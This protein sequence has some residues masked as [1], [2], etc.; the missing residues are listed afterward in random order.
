MRLF[1]PLE[2]TDTRLPPKKRI[3]G[4]EREGIS[5]AVQ[6]DEV[7]NAGLIN[8]EIGITPIVA[9]H[10]TLLDT[11]RLFE[12][13]VEGDPD[14]LTFSFLEG[15]IVDDKTKGEWTSEGVCTY[16]RLRGKTLVPLLH[17]NA[18]WFAWAAFYPETV[19]LPEKDF[20]R[21][22]GSGLP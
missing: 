14:V 2:R 3:L 19:I 17:T 10:D 5:G 4:I 13:R 1:Y 7:K 6:I 12:R 8:M 16:G 18:M 20:V 21:Q 15:R 22:Q 11:V 9:F